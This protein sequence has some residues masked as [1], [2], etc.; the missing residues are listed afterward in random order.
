L[1]AAPPHHQTRFRAIIEH[2]TTVHRLL[3][4][5]RYRRKMGSDLRT[6]RKPRLI[7]P[8]SYSILPLLPNIKD[9]VREFARI[10][11]AKKQRLAHGCNANISPK[12][13]KANPRA[14][15][16]DVS[17]QRTPTACAPQ[18]TNSLKI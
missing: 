6:R 7:L 5:F 18:A 17:P 14:D 3:R 4:T 2:P 13:T 15:S 10:E 12:R 11:A 9:A 8:K 16:Q 1:P